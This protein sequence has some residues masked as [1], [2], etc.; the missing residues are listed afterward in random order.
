[1]K[2]LHFVHMWNKQ[3]LRLKER[4]EE[5]SPSISVN[6]QGFD[7]AFYSFTQDDVLK[8]VFILSDRNALYEPDKKRNCV[9]RYTAAGEIKLVNEHFLYDIENKI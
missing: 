4:R 1:M 3:L 2:V 8:Q 7:V 6:T 5:L 9:K